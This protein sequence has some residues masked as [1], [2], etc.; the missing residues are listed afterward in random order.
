M[1]SPGKSGVKP[2][3]TPD[4]A[5]LY[6]PAWRR[7]LPRCTVSNYLGASSAEHSHGRRWIRSVD[8]HGSPAHCTDGRICAMSPRVPPRAAAAAACIPARSGRCKAVLFRGH[9][10]YKVLACEHIRHKW[11]QTTPYHE[12]FVTN[13]QR[14]HRTTTHLEYN[15]LSLPELSRHAEPLGAQIYSESIPR[16]FFRFVDLRN[17]KFSPA[18]IAAT[19]S[20]PFAGARPH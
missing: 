17:T 5:A 20:K 7:V 11:T 2:S 13:G 16:V 9:E 18:S 10:R 19:V 14:P 6:P 3:T 12:T 8:P 15:S 4:C 1:S